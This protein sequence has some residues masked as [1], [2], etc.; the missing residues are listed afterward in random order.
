MHADP[1]YNMTHQV[2]SENYL[3]AML[4]RMSETCHRYWIEKVTDN[5]CYVGYSNPNEYGIES[6]IQIMFP[7]YRMQP[8]RGTV[9]VVLDIYNETGGRDEYDRDAASQTLAQFLADTP[10]L[11]RDSKGRWHT[12]RVIEALPTPYVEKY[13]NGKRITYSPDVTGTE[14]DHF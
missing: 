2:V 8:Y 5:F 3:A 10:P 14:E 4:A 7:V 11:H 9:L 13:E 1:I 12:N 6:P